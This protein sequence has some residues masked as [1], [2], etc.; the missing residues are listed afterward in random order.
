[1]LFRIILF[2]SILLSLNCKSLEQFDVQCVSDEF[3]R[4][5]I[6]SSHNTSQPSHSSKDEDCY[7]SQDT[8]EGKLFIFIK[9]SIGSIV[10]MSLLKIKKDIN[11]LQSKT[12]KKKL[13]LVL[14]ELKSV[15]LLI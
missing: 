6:D 12:T 11:I 3:V 4:N 2:L 5:G 7:C 15:K 9:P 1:M 14:N 13:L 10:L 8:L